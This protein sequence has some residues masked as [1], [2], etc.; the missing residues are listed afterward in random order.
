MRPAFFLLFWGQASALPQPAAEPG[1]MLRD[2]Q[3]YPEPQPLWVGWIYLQCGVR[4]WVSPSPSWAG[5]PLT[6]P[7]PSTAPE[8]TR[9]SGLVACHLHI[10]CMFMPSQ[11]QHTMG[12]P[13]VTLPSSNHLGS[14]TCC[15]QIPL[16]PAH[17]P[18]RET[19]KAVVTSGLVPALPWQAGQALG[20]FSSQTTAQGR[21]P[22]GISPFISSLAACRWGERHHH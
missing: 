4:T 3:P 18:C 6:L 15:P 19:I 14:V 22:S 5:R 9:G 21:R 13:K 20:L 16:N 11:T 12:G 1:L 10:I 17:A 7:A 8:T 2:P